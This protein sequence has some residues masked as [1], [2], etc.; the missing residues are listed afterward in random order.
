MSMYIL[1]YLKWIADKDLLYSMGN[2][3]QCYVAA[4]KGGTFGEEWIYIYICMAESAVYLK[5]SQRCLLIGYIYKIKREEEK[6]NANT[7]K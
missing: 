1:L 3:A 5:L 6:N 2:S 4:W 7:I